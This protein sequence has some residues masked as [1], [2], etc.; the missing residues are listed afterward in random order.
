MAA[1]DAMPAE[2]AVTPF[3]EPVLGPWLRVVLALGL[4]ALVAGAVL[5]VATGRLSLVDVQAWV[6]AQGAWAPVVYVLV[7]VAATVLVLPGVAMLAVAALLFPLPTALGLAWLGASL[8]AAAAFVVARLFGRGFVARLLGGR[9]ARLD[10]Q[11]AERGF[12]VVLLLRLTGVP[13]FNLLNFA[14]GLT[15]VRPVDFLAA[16]AL[17]LVPYVAAVVLLVNRIGV[18]PTFFDVVTDPVLYLAAGLVVA[19]VAVARRFKRRA[20]AIVRSEPPAGP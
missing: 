14:A 17:G 11:V 5:L 16:S 20:A 18:A 2:E 8:G 4:L 3:V 15:R 13:P 6:Q 7:F 1:G 19:L 10:D 12:Q 9:L